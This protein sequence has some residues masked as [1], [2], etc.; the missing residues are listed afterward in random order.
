MSAPP[1]HTPPHALTRR[2]GT[3]SARAALFSASGA[4]LG[5]HSRATTTFRSPADARIFEQSTDD[6]WACIA[7][8]SRAVLHAAQVASERVKGVG[9]DATCSLAVVDGA[10]TPVA[11]SPTQQGW[12]HGTQNVILWADHRAE[13]EAHEINASGSRVL[14]FVGGTMSVSGARVC[15]RH[16]PAH[17]S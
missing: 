8:C 4:L 7:E 2:S 1:T 13:Q 14:D 17:A 5:A 11:V 6:I 3:G 15:S 12:T 16:C 9:F 10:G